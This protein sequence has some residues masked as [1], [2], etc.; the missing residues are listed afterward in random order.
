MELK[1]DK[2]AIE[3][4]IINYKEEQGIILDAVALNY[5]ALVD[6]NNYICNIKKKNRIIRQNI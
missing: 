6:A 2:R 1:L 4:L 3:D 5:E